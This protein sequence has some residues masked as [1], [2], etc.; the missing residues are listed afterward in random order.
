MAGEILTWCQQ[1]HLQILTPSSLG[2]QA[3][4][5]T[6]HG[7]AALRRVSLALPCLVAGVLG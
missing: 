2:A 1:T 3:P 7:A 6:A 5:L 4:L